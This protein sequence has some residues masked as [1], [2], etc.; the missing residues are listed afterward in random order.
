MNWLLKP[1]IRPFIVLAAMASLMLNMALIVPSLYM[2]QVFDRVFSSRSGETL[3]MLTLLALL[4]LA[5]AF[6]MDRVR[7]M[8]LMRA[9]RIVDETMSSAALTSVLK[10][11]ASGR[12]RADRSAVQDIARLR[13]FLAS[14]AV[15][16]LFDAP[17]LPIHLLVIFALHPALGLAALGCAGALFGLG[18]LT[19]RLVRADSGQLVASGRL[20]AGRIDALTRNAEVLVGMGM[21]G[22]AVAI[23]QAAHQNALQVQERL[24]DT[25][26]ALSALGR[27]LRQFV[28]VGLLGLGAWLVVAGDATP[29]IMI[30]AT[31]LAARAFQPVEQLIAGWQSLVQVRAAWQR[32]HGQ[33][34]EVPHEQALR[35]PPMRGE[36]GLERVA[37]GMDAGRPAVIKG[38]TLNLAPGECLGLIGPS[39]SGKTTLV[40]LMLGLR[41]PSAGMVRL[42][43][44]DLAAWPR[45]QLDGAVGYLPQDVELFS[46]TVAHNIARL[47]TIDSDRVIEAA[48]LAGVHEMIMRLPK[49]YETEIGDGGCVLSGGQRQRIALARAVYGGPK[50]V[51]LDEPNA[52]L[53]TEGEE[54]LSAALARLKQDGATVVLVTHRPA[55]I[56]HADTVAV[57]RDGAL[58]MIGPR[59][60][61]LGRLN[62]TALPAS[63]ASPT[64]HPLRRPAADSERLQEVHA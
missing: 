21:L 34:M 20:A 57:L 3:A 8:L 6:C 38:I 23:W 46:G 55:L 24:G 31:V 32:L 18:L 51:V 59:E 52:N 62:G 48:R 9:G 44:L 12:F 11:S 39:A 27:T 54:A 50:F 22:N 16:A 42:D 13:G 56:R 17:W 14:P 26:A 49:A 4:A 10:E 36:L 47:G 64:V 33:T 35:L 63:Q 1:R 41:T 5:L 60:R 61:V 25:Q 2:L 40:R 30:A 28:Q 37:L 19:E 45:D 43:G 29:G 58:D 53:D 15:H 7:A